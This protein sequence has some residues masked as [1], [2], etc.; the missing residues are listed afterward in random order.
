MYSV[1]R[2]REGRRRRLAAGARR[3]GPRRTRESNRPRSTSSGATPSRYASPSRATSRAADRPAPSSSSGA[4]P[5]A[6]RGGCARP[7]VASASGHSASWI[8]SRWTGA[9]A[10]IGEEP[11]QRP[12]PRLDAVEEDAAAVDVER[13]PAERADPDVG[14]AGGRADR[15]V[16]APASSA[17]GRGLRR[18]AARRAGVGSAPTPRQRRARSRRRRSRPAA[19][20]V[21]GAHRVDLGER[22]VGEHAAPPACPAARAEALGADAPGRARRA[23]PAAAAASAA[24][25]R[26]HASSTPRPR[27]RNASA[28]GVRRARRG[29][30][31]A[32]AAP[33]RGQPGERRAPRILAGP[34]TV[35]RAPVGGLVPGRAAP[36]AT[37]RAARATATRRAR[38][39]STARS[40]ARASQR[41]PR[42]HAGHGR[43]EAR[44]GGRERARVARG[45]R[46]P[47][48]RA[49]PRRPRP[50]RGAAGR[51]RPRRRGSSR[52]ASSRAAW[53][54]SR[55]SPARRA[56]DDVGRRHGPGIQPGRERAAARRGAPPPP[57][58]AR[59]RP[60]RGR[61]PRA[62]RP[63]GR[64]C[65][66]G[67]PRPARPTG[68]GARWPAGSSSIQRPSRLAASRSPSPA[69][70]PPDA[71]PS[72]RRGSRPAAPRRSAPASS[73]SRPARAVAVAGRGLADLLDQHPVEVL[74]QDLVVAV[75]VA[76]VLDRDGE[77]AAPRQLVEERAAPP[78]AAEPVA[79]AARTG[80]RA[81]RCRARNVWSS[82][83]QPDHARS[84]RGTRAAAGRTIPG[85]RGP[86]AAPR[87]TGRGSRGGTAGGPAAQPSVRRASTAR[88]A[89]GTGSW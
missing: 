64:R 85:R 57:A 50:P 5:T 53:P 42:Q 11:E 60:R 77:H 69:E 56:P 39:S 36:P 62:P 32:A 35:R 3:R 9:P 17:G 15:R 54:G 4:G 26:A 48:G 87:R 23:D 66:P 73:S 34:E 47:S 63:S 28:G 52:R 49:A 24:E 74:A 88:S 8:T 78:G 71:R 33:R 82:V 40:N 16:R 80:G 41:S 29:L 22:R 27:R 44:D 59:A 70:Q 1:E 6:R 10:W 19:G 14:A 12:D 37:A 46:R 83:G 84:G 58:P 18:A 45:P 89:G 25:R 79:Q 43:A 75:R 65:A 38:P 61:T 21:G 13:E 51:A 68:R 30:R 81:R 2:R 20:V 76:A 7:A 86:A 72:P 31:P 67:G 55:T